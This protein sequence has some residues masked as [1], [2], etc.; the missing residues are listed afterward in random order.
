MDNL[1]GVE[2]G[3]RPTKRHRVLLGFAFC[4]FLSA[5]TLGSYWYGAMQIAARISNHGLSI[6]T[7]QLD[8]GKAWEQPDFPMKI[9]VVNVSDSELAVKKIMTSCRCTSVAPRE[10]VLSPGA[11]IDIGIRLDLR[12]Q[13]GDD[14]ESTIRNFKTA[15]TPIVVGKPPTADGW[16]IHGTV[17]RGFSTTPAVMAYDDDI[18]V[19]ESPPTISATINCLAAVA[20]FDAECDRTLARVH[21]IRDRLG[22]FRVEIA[23][24]PMHAAGELAFDVW[25][26]AYLSDGIELP[27]LPVHVVGHVYDDVKLIPE[28]VSFGS[29]EAGA[30]AQSE[31]A[32]TSRSGRAVASVTAEPSTGVEIEPIFD[33]DPNVKRLR[34][35]LPH[36]SAGAYSRRIP[37]NIMLKGTTKLSAA[38]LL[39][40]YNGTASRSPGS[41]SHERHSEEV[42]Q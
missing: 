10:F 17:L 23:P 5:T 19:D 36:A 1:V 27:R 31:I 8:F 7:D 41:T 24:L 13:P 26:T 28:I 30:S 20:K 37:L 38:N 6:A 33:D 29:L 4:L 11:A 42:V 25:L 15:I 14:P 9:H 3:S 21:V 39:V 16:T 22:S 34:I 12:P 18:L 40:I 32:V 2:R 35:I